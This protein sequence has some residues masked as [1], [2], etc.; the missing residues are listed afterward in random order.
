MKYLYHLPVSGFND[1]LITL[2]ESLTYCKKYN[3]TLL[4]DT[5]NSL[6]KINFAE[7]FDLSKLIEINNIEIICDSGKIRELDIQDSA[8]FYPTYYTKEMYTNILNN[9]ID[10]KYKFGTGFCDSLN[11]RSCIPNTDVTDDI[12]IYIQC[13]VGISSFPI[14]KNILLKQELIDSCKKRYI[15]ILDRCKWANKKSYI[16]VQVRNTDY[17]SDYKLLFKKNKKIFENNIIYLATDSVEVIEF[18]KKKWY[19]YNE[20]LYISKK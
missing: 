12:I 4:F 6:Y 3:R 8:T 14:F 1:T 10:I 2:N 5:L 11:N 18:F 20:F 17:H 7:Y 9:K 16:S 15:E 13:G 19:R